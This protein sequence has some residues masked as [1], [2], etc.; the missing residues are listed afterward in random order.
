MSQAR[1]VTQIHGFNGFTKCY[2][3]GKRSVES[4]E[5]NVN[6]HEY[7]VVRREWE[8]TQ[9]VQKRCDIGCEIIYSSV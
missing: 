4:E 3:F 2:H 9:V 8:V 7:L 5:Q 1:R 6:V